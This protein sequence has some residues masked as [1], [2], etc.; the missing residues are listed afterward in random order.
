MVRE[1]SDPQNMGHEKGL[2][3]DVSTWTNNDDYEGVIREG[4]DQFNFSK[5]S[6]GTPRSSST[7]AT[8]LVTP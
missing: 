1:S 7:M 3:L 8:G 2:D 6:P 5:P 4:T